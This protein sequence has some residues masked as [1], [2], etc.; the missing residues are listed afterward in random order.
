MDEEKKDRRKMPKFIVIIFIILLCIA[1]YFP[2][3][4]LV[5]RIILYN[6][7][8]NI[9]EYRTREIVNDPND[10]N[11][12]VNRLVVRLCIDYFGKEETYHLYV[13]D[14]G[15]VFTGRIHSYS[16]WGDHVLAIEDHNNET[17]WDN[18]EM[19]YFGKM[20]GDELYRI[21][22]LRDK[23]D[24]MTKYYDVEAEYV[25]CYGGDENEFPVKNKTVEVDPWI[26]AFAYK[27]GRNYFF[28]R[29]AEDGIRH[30]LYDKNAN[31]ML[32]LIED[33]WYFDQWMTDNYGADWNIK[34]KLYRTE[35][36]LVHPL[37]L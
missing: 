34:V 14:D 21:R 37:D 35:K 32:C 18:V 28:F 3:S 36:E 30:Y 23:A 10:Y 11:L 4:I 16:Q 9:E 25:N 27:D 19:V 1:L 31:K 7:C 26:T 6:E 20:S 15:R 12:D 22:T 24:F 33:S 29:Q 2:L 13:F 17:V 8:S 5:K